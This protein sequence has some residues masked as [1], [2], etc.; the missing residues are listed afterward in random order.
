VRTEAVREKLLK[1]ASSALTDDGHWCESASRCDE[2]GRTRG[3]SH[4]EHLYFHSPMVNFGG[5]GCAGVSSPCTLL[6]CA[7]TYS[8]TFTPPLPLLSFRP[9]YFCPNSSL[10]VQPACGLHQNLVSAGRQNSVRTR[11]A[12]GCSPS[13]GGVV[14]L[15]EL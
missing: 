15:M 8:P 13:P 9:V 3:E 12:G 4:Q 7:T 5:R 2:R 14:P 6:A 10:C 11:L 1:K